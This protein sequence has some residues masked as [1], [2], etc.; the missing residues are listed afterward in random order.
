MAKLATMKVWAV[1]LGLAVHIKTPNGRNIVIDLGSK[2]GVSPL[3][4]LKGENVGYMVITHPHHDHFSDIRNIDC[5]YPDVL[6][7][8]KAF[9]KEELMD[10]VR[11]A[12]VLA[13]DAALLKKKILRSIVIL[14]TDLMD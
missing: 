2:D 5:A 3:Q 12:T 11:I 14:P 6:W 10:G 9:T 4:S 13:A 8:V 7:R 1:D